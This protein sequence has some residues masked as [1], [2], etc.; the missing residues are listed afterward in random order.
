MKHRRRQIQF[1]GHCLATVLL[2]LTWTSTGLGQVLPIPY[3]EYRLDPTSGSNSYPP[4]KVAPQVSRVHVVL[5]GDTD[6]RRVGK[7]SRVDLDTWNVLLRSLIPD[8]NR[9]NV[10]ELYGQNVNKGTILGTIGTLRPGPDDAVV[11]IWSGHGAYNQ[12]G[13]F[14]QVP[15]DPGLYRSDVVAAISRLRPRL[16]VVLSSA[17]NEMCPGDVER[18]FG[19]PTTSYHDDQRFERD[20]SP[21]AASL[22]LEPRG[23]VDINGASE[24]ELGFSNS[25]RGSTFLAPL[26]EYLWTFRQHRVDWP[27]LVGEM[28]PLVQRAMRTAWPDG[29]LDESTGKRY[30]TQSPRVWSFPGQRDKRVLG[31]DVAD[32]GGDGVRVVGIRVGAPSQRVASATTGQIFSLE[33]N[34][35]I[36]A[37]ND[38][39]ITTVEQCVQAV[40]SSPKQMKLLVRDCR[41]GTADTL[42]AR[43]PD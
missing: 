37:V 6:D 35:I 5:A 18:V 34:D 28:G 42:I 29:Y 23:V 4:V 22:F 38:R 26:A 3:G 14:L 21:I 32:N 2:P 33:S 30:F 43:L 16:T 19:P 27:T 36:L 10:V 31:V 8:E 15:G 9:L 13:H 11:F 7:G 39:S 12:N 1:V 24:G 25:V 17:C 40:K 20:I 41:T